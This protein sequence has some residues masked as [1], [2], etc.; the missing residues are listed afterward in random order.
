MHSSLTD[1]NLQ[2]L[3]PYQALADT[4]HFVADLKST[5]DG[6]ADSPVIVIGAHYSGTLA[7]WFRQKFPHLAV[8]AWAS[9]APV[10]SVIDQHEFKELAAEAYRNIGGDRC[11][12][13]LESGFAEMEQMV[14]AERFDELFEMFNL[15]EPLVTRNDVSTFFAEIAEF[16]AIIAQFAT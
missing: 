10:L 4:A 15:C 3:T 6:A 5:L 2:F 9:S 8:A 12:D 7:A 1:V 14:V 13:A 16:Y 11:Y